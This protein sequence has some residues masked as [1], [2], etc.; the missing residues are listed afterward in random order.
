MTIQTVNIAWLT[1]CFVGRK[2][3]AV[4]FLRKR[5]SIR[6]APTRQESCVDTLQWIGPAWR[7]VGDALWWQL[8][9]LSRA[10]AHL[11]QCGAWRQLVSKVENFSDKKME[12]VGDTVAIVF[13]ALDNNVNGAQLRGCLNKSLSQRFSRYPFVCAVLPFRTACL[14]NG[15]KKNLGWAPSRDPMT[16]IL[17]PWLSATP[18]SMYEKKKR[19]KAFPTLS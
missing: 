12:E 3:H 8:G 10:Q 1:S 5:S 19:R 17:A 4:D 6:H 18:C 9:K 2:Q 16:T 15:N 11:L 7:C 14:M 13:T